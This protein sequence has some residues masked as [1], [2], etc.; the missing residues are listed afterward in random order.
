[1]EK[2]IRTIPATELR[3]DVTDGEKPKIRGYAAVFDAIS[4]DLGGFREKIKRGA[5]AKSLLDG[6]DVLALWNHDDSHVLGR[7]R[8]GTLKVYEDIHGLKVE[9][10]PPDTQW[11]RDLMVTIQRGDVDQ[12]SFGFRVI[13]DSWEQ[14]A[15]ELP[16][17]T[18]EQVELFDVA[19]VTIPAYPQTTVGVRNMAQRLSTPNGAAQESA[20]GGTDQA[21]QPTDQIQADAVRLVGV[22][23]EMIEKQI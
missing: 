11:A 4:N 6:A 13:A 15:G 8:S 22:K 23:L 16:L 14:R 1:M 17:R 21:D 18:L 3:V 19:P 2:E 7:V 12:M 5:F 10:D 20:T 9:I